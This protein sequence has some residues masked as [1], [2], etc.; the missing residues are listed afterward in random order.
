MHDTINAFT[1]SYD[2]FDKSVLCAYHE[3]FTVLGPGCAMV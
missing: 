2:S 1:I 3:P